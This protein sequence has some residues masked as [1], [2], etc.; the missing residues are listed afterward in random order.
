MTRNIF[1]EN[2]DR[3]GT[4][5]FKWEMTK[6]LFGED[7][8][9]PMWVADMDFRAPAAVTEAFQKRLDHGVYGYTF[10]SDETYRVMQQWMQKRHQWPI[11][12]S[13]ITLSPSVVSAMS[14]VI[15]AYTKPGDKVMLQSP[16]YAPF[17]EMIEKNDRV[18][19]NS[20]LRLNM[21]GQYEIDFECFEN[22]LKEGVKLFLLCSPHNPGG[23]VWTKE[24]LLKIGE[25]CLRYNCL[26]FADEIHSDLVLEPFKHIPIA[27]LEGLEKIVI[28][29]ISPSKTFNLAGLNV[30]SVII[31]EETLRNQFN[32]VQRKQ[33]FFSVGTFGLIGVEAAYRHGEAWLEELLKYIKENVNITKKYIEENLPNVKLIE[34]QG[35]YLLWFDCRN[36]GLSDI[37]LKNRLLN[38]G[39]LALEPGAK[40]GP[41][42]EGF[43]RM[44]I[45]CPREIL[46]EGL[47]RFKKALQ[48]N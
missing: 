9:L 39:K 46:K 25:L 31:Q 10:A 40:Y 20:P 33:G 35:T 37:E 19:V 23:R 29:C 14:T 4:N 27:S 1:D 15:R 38:K 30:S 12:K 41:G 43:V 48:T 16:V 17:F 6:E 3:F 36:L 7:D 26:I 8:L 32:E 44:N 2:V 45:A 24:E 47:K 21:K 13:W 22:R 34:P 11:E 42:G 5:S 18:V 28:T